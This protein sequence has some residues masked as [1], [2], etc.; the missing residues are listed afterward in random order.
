[1]V[2]CCS[3]RGT[4]GEDLVQKKC[5]GGKNAAIATNRRYFEPEPKLAVTELKKEVSQKFP[6]VKKAVSKLISNGASVE[7]ENTKSTSNSSE[8]KSGEDFQAIRA[9][10]LK[11]VSKMRDR[12]R[13]VYME[14]TTVS[15]RQV[16]M[17]DTTVSTTRLE[18]E[19]VRS[20]CMYP[21]PEEEVTFVQAKYA[22]DASVDA[23]LYVPLDDS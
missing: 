22:F 14:D 1:M 20:V 11:L 16:Y 19:Q 10:I 5:K 6:E 23:L 7:E 2:L 9:R 8:Q 12:H 17:E 4:L 3:A 21:L 18:A 15:D 13:Q